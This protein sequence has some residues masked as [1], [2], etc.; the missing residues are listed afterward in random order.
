MSYKNTMKLF[1]SNFT[2]AWK[3]LVYLLIC[4]FLFGV[5][6]YTLVSP[7]IS[8]LQNAGLFEEMNELINLIYN[9]PQDIAITLSK[10][11]KLIFTCIGANFSRIYI[12]LF[13]SLILCLIL[14]YVLYQSSIYNLSSILFQKFT[15]NMEVGYCQ[16]Y[17]S[18]FWKSIKFGLTSLIFS[19]P[20]F[21]VNI[22]LIIA[23][24]LIADSVLMAISGLALLSFF[25]LLIHATQLTLFSHF[26]G[27]L[28]A[29]DS[30]AFS[31]FLKS[32]PITLKQFF[33]ITGS[34][35]IIILTAILV[36]GVIGLFTF[37]AGLC[38]T[39]PATCVLM[40]I[41]KIVTFLNINGNR[42]YLS[43]SIIYNP[44]K[45]VV[46]KDEYVSTFIPPEE[47]K[48]ITTTKMKR[49]FKV[50]TTKKTTNKKRSNKK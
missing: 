7:I 14:P 12:N 13:A 47:T 9:N 27:S 42:Y 40:C 33:K 6:S 17:L 18:N 35:I 3:Q 43:S 46:K 11:V 34:S 2:L 28:I 44:Q 8:V 37:F 22:L 49:N 10:I 38:I 48:E 1:V 15:M 39:I 20:F 19:L 30:N 4:F 32:F 45:Y 50:N 31:T 24:I 23:Y 21:I 29:N 41:F 25:S 16:N 36:N 5:C 26:T